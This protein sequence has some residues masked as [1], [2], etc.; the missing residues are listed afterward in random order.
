MMR[1]NALRDL[2]S[3]ACRAQPDSVVREEM[4]SLMGVL[5]LC[6]MSHTLTIR[7]TDELLAWL[8]EVSRRT[9]IPVGSIVRQQ[10][11][12]AKAAK[13][14]Q[15]FLRHAGEI[16]GAPDLSSRKGFSRQ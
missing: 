14:N 13:G 5:Q 7:L 8:K 3:L 1:E 15:R 12:G 16:K 9:G 10:L 11:E 6:S 2:Q 4:S